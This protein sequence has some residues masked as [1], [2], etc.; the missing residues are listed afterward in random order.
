MAQHH[1][2]LQDATTGINLDDFHWEAKELPG[3]PQDWEVRMRRASGGRAEGV[4]L[5][6]INNGPMTVTVIPTRGMGIWRAE[7]SGRKLGWQSPVRGPVHPAWV[8]NFDPSGLGWLE[9][10]DELVCRCGLGSNGAP[11]FTDQGVLQYPLHGRIANLPASRVEAIVNDTAG[12]ITLQGTIEETRFHFQK[13]R[14]VSSL[15]IPFGTT[16][17]SWHDQVTNFGGTPATMQMLYHVNFGPPLLQSGAEL[18]VPAARIVPLEQSAADTGTESWSKYPAPQ[19]GFVEQVYV[20]DLLTDAEQNTQVLLKNPQGDEGISL[21]WNKQSLRWFSQWKNMVAEEDGYVTGLEPATNLPNTHDFEESH[22][23]VV[24]LQPA[25]SWETTVEL[26]W[27]LNSGEV[28]VS[29]N[30]VRQLQGDTQPELMEKPL[31]EWSEEG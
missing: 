26:A 5:V 14:L 7:C 29:E 30:A 10:F 20:F 15:T 23:R 9:G 6:E 3:T 31:P 8:P 17:M 16:R 19:A 11:Q 24:R 2:I 28:N 13:L 18:V 12:T 1:Q 27:H 25:E 21:R 22:D 4:Y